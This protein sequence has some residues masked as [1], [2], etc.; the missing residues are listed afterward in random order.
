MTALDVS[1][2][3]AGYGSAN[4]L[5][6]ITFSAGPGEITVVLGANGAG[7]TTLLR[8]I[9]GLVR[10]NGSIRLG[11]LELVGQRPERIAAHGVAHV[12][13]GRGTFADLTVEENLRVG[14]HG[15]P[16]ARFL[17]NLERWY[18]VF[19]R[20][21]DRRNQKAGWLSGGEQQMLALT[22]AMVRDPR[23]LLLDEPSLGLAPKITQE[24]FAVLSTINREHD[25]AILLVEQNA[26]IALQYASQAFVLETGR[27]V[28][29]GSAAA[30]AA[31]PEVRRAYL[32]Q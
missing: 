6:D 3:E 20:L 30:I 14:G 9:S 4:V 19:P 31:D 13:Q 11:N 7:K 5:N 10:G 8:G 25:L 15:V 12:P 23:L 27:L 16:R 26:D 1:G 22:R 32:G 17:Q 29:S 2:F 18:D 24:F 28:A 21:H